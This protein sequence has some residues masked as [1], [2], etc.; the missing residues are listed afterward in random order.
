M[1]LE[2]KIKKAELYEVN[3]N[4]E[5]AIILYN[6]IVEENSSIQN[7]ERLGWCLSRAGKYN[8]A[9]RYFMDLEEK[10][11]KMAKWKY[12]IGY[13]YYCKKDWDQAVKYFEETLKIR[14]NYFVVKY[15][16]SYAYVQLAGVYKKLTKPEFWKA[17]GHIKDCHELWNN[18]DEKTRNKEKHTYF[19][20]NFLHGK[21]LMDLPNHRKEA[22]IYFIDALKI[23]NDEICRYNLSKTYYLIGN[24]E[25]AKKYI[26]DSNNYY[27]IELNA[28]IE[29]KLKNYDIA[30]ETINKLMKKRK[31]D[32]LFA[33]LAE[34]YLLKEDN[35]KAFKSANEAIKM[36]YKNHK[37]HFILAKVY[38]KSG[39]YNS[40]LRELD[41]AIQLKI[42]YYHS[43]YEE[44]NLLK[45]EILDMIPDNY[46]E[47]SNILDELSENNKDNIHI[48][49]INEYD[50]NK[51]FGFI[52]YDNKKIFFHISDCE[53]SNVI[54]K[55]QVI[56]HITRGK[57]NK[58]KAIDVKWK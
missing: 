24:Y 20:V 48:G 47:N 4:W 30:I 5:E 9:I 35:K 1:T 32:Y 27:I 51:G 57:N 45:K 38:Y 50:K 26:P 16:I 28:Y 49:T 19:D 43:E 37:N 53:F 39:L 10:E 29:A 55:K 3:S 36:N 22:T 44:A 34:V 56:F 12:M 14:P 11:P 21:M 17:L 13:Q 40:A 46:K 33:F 31:K 42:K 18:F 23:K 52:I 15:R 25:E 6:E 2:E 54:E 8:E 7:I 58:L 41:I